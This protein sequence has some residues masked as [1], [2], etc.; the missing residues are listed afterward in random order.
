MF[1]LIIF[2]LKKIQTGL[3]TESLF[4]MTFEIFENKKLTSKY[5]FNYDSIS[6]DKS[7]E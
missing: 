6:L 3:N 5:E 1:D 4:I 2:L 7:I